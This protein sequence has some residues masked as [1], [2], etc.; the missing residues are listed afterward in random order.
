MR[1]ER[2]A[3]FTLFIWVLMMAVGTAIAFMLWTQLPDPQSVGGMKALQAMQVV[4]LFVLPALGV[5]WLYREEPAKWLGLSV[6]PAPK[7]WLAAALLMIVML[8]GINLMSYWNQQLSLPDCL[9]GLEERMKLLEEQSAALLERF[10]DTTSVWGLMINL[11]LMALLPAVG[12]ELAFRG[13]LLHT[14]APE[15]SL[16]VGRRSL[17]KPEAGTE[18]REPKTPHLA[19]WATAIIF[20]FVHFQ[21]YGFVPRMLMG[22]LFGYVL[23]WTGSLWV[24]MLMHFTNNAMVTLLYFICLS[25]GYDTETMDAIGHGDTLWL[26]ILSIAVSI[27]GIYLLRRSLT[28]S[29]ASSRTSAGS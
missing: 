20:S 1:R 5:T 26:G 10:M 18:N 4:F 25:H 23:C 6:F 3:F 19:I 29:S 17:D 27:V 8:P 14:M 7:V 2:S 21:F 9:S 15:G 22:G 12:E 11:G 13:V 24:A 28:M 16:V